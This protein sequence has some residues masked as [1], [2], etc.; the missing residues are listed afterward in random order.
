MRQTG[1][2][3]V[4]PAATLAGEWVVVTGGSKGIGRGIAERMLESGANVV[5]VARNE[6]DIDAA[7]S[8]LSKQA[9]DTQT[10]IGLTADVGDRA[11]FGR[12]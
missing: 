5:L 8:E 1:D 3:D 4:D 2:V 9:A 7:V 6:A 10:V 12:R 11:R